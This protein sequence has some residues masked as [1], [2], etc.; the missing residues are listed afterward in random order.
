VTEHPCAGACLTT[1]IRGNIVQLFEQ[2][3]MTSLTIH[4]PEAT[5]V[6]ERSANGTAVMSSYSVR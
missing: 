6:L 5:I 2:S 1:N 3:G 4:S